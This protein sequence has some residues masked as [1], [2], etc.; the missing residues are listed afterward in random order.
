MAHHHDDNMKVCTNCRYWQDWE[1]RVHARLSFGGNTHI[2]EELR[3]CKYSPCPN[4]TGVP[5]QIFTDGG[6]TCS[7]FVKE[8]D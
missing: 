7:E 3:L 2:G 4:V 6:F 1:V 8:E 5:N